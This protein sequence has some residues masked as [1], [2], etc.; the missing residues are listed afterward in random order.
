MVWPCP[1]HPESLSLGY[2]IFWIFLH[3]QREVSVTSD[4]YAIQKISCPLHLWEH[5]FQGRP[6]QARNSRKLLL[7]PEVILHWLLSKLKSFWYTPHILD[8]QRWEETFPKA[9]SHL[10][11]D[12]NKD[13]QKDYKTWFNWPQRAEYRHD[14]YTSMG[15]I[16]TVKQNYIHQHRV[17]KGF[18]C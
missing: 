14:S 5:F 10:P 9:E 2:R 7:R 1:W 13:P 4:N 12:Y 16:L 18:I 17:K 8:Y 3:V 11:P 15:W 6:S